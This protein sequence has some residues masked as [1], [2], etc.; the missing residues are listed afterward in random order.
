MSTPKQHK[1]TGELSREESNPAMDIHIKEAIQKL[2][3]WHH[4]RLT[5]ATTVVRPPLQYIGSLS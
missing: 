5:T 1:E 4:N 2:T 3:D